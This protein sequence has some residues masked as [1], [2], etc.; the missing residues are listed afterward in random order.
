LPCQFG[1]LSFGVPWD[2]DTQQMF[3]LY[4]EVTQQGLQLAG[5]VLGVLVS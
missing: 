1:A 5:G 2:F 4:L 3:L